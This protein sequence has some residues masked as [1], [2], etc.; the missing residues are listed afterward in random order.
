MKENTAFTTS[1]ADTIERTAVFSISKS[2][3]FLTFPDLH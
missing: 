2:W 1:A 3:K